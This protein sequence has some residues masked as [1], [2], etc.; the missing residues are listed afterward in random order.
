MVRRRAAVGRMK[1][2]IL[3]GGGHAHLRVLAELARQ[4]LR[5]WEVLLLT[6][7]PTQIYSGMLPGWVAG[8]YFLD[9]CTIE[10]QRLASA[11]GASLVLDEAV[12][13]DADA[14]TLQARSS[15]P[16][17][18]DVLSIDVGSA[19]G[20]GDLAGA[21]EHATLVRPLEGFVAAWETM[22]ERP[23]PRGGALQLVIVGAGA[24]GVELAFAAQHRFARDGVH[25]C[26]HLV[27][28]RSAP[29]ASA[30]V[31]ARHQV[32]NLLRHKGIQWHADTR[33]AA[34]VPQGVLFEDG[35]RL[36]AD[37]CWLVTGPRPHRWFAGSGLA[38]DDHGFVQVDATLQSTSHPGVFVA[39]DAA[40]HASPVPR[41]GVYAV[42]AGP[43]LARNLLAHCTGGALQAWK[44][45]AR[46]LY[47]LS[48]GD[49][50]AIAIWNGWTWSG[51]WVWA[52]KNRIDQKFVASYER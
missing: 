3:L 36:P 28:S 13:L 41:S 11:A 22:R 19:P 5:Q 26:V 38:T 52:W 29:L 43:V 8:H 20:A 23:R 33:A 6:P 2:L 15:G 44:P 7:R 18:Y 17:R 14:R 16:Y 21:A 51:R 31:A 46:A 37:A 47:L 1:R 4:P 45:S 49:R 30:P 9:E 48:T 27:G 50:H 39:G 25:A 32:L 34:V 42:R 10:L 40:A 35:R 12:A 24:A